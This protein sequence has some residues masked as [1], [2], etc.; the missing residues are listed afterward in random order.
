MMCFIEKY[1]SVFSYLIAVDF[2]IIKME[3]Q[4]KEKISIYD[5]LVSLLIFEFLYIAL[6]TIQ[7]KITALQE[8]TLSLHTLQRTFS[9]FWKNSD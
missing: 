3:S 1:V 7:K 8:R 2:Q 4:Q 6:Y 9:V 5:S